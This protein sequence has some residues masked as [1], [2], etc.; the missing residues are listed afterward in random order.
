VLPK[1]G[2]GPTAEQR[3]AGRYKILFHGEAAD[4]RSMKAIVRGDR[5][6]GYGST[7]K[8]IAECALG[9]LHDV[10]PATSPGGIWSPGTAMGWPSSLGCRP[11]QA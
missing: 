6:P 7:S 2:A 4:G 8:T 3:E 5:D 1:P 10:D 9:F 11:R